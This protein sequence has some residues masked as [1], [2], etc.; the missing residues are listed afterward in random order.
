MRF[1]LDGE[2]KTPVP[3]EK[4]S[5]LAVPK[6]CYKSTGYSNYQGRTSSSCGRKPNMAKKQGFRPRIPDPTTGA[7][8]IPAPIVASG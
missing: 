2:A 1:I 7:P 8:G 4:T 6:H 3:H 5:K